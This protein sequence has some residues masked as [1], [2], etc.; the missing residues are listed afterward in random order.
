MSNPFPEYKDCPECDS[1]MMRMSEVVDGDTGEI[2]AANYFCIE[3]S[4]QEDVSR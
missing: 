2:L 3:C 4:N 1:R